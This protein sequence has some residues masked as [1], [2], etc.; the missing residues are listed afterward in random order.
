MYAS[1]GVPE[2][3]RYTRQSVLV[4]HLIKDRYQQH[5]K[6]LAF[7]FLP[8]DE[9]PSLIEQSNQLGQRSAIRQ[10]RQRIRQILSAAR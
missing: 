7:P 10:F 1:L 6:S 8:I 4:Y 3:W 5:E 9:I 2:L